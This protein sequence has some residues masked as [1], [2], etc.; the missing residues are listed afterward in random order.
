MGLG[1]VLIHPSSFIPHPSL[2]PPLLPVPVGRLPQPLVQGGRHGEPQFAGR[3]VAGTGPGTSPG[4]AGLVEVEIPRLAAK[5]RKCRGDQTEGPDGNRRQPNHQGPAAAQGCTHHTPH[6]GKCQVP[7]GR[8]KVA[9]LG[10]GN[11]VARIAK[12][13]LPSLG[14]ENH[15]L[16]EVVGMDQ[17]NPMGPPSGN[18]M[19]P[20]ASDRLEDLVGGRIGLAKH[21]GRTKDCDRHPTGPLPGRLLAG[22][23]APA[24]VETGAGGSLSTLGRRGFEGPIAANDETTIRTGGVVCAAQARATLATPSRFT[25]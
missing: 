6:F 20:K 8:D 4:L 17:G 21:D 9:A 5:S 14:G 22:Q 11:R 19:D 18:D 15:R 3:G 7:F 10:S 12:H 13:P 16:Q 2:Q 23:F 1:P 24:V 25:W